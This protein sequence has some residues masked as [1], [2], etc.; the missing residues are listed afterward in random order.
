MM[1][2]TDRHCRV[3][4]RLLSKRARLYSEMVTTEAVLHGRRERLIGFDSRE[5]P[6]ALQLGGSNPAR[7]ARAAMVAEEMGYDEVNLNVGCPSDRVQNGRF[8]ACLMAEPDLVADCV[9]GMMAAVSIPIT[10]KCRIG[11][12][13][14]DSE[15]DFQR[16]VERVGAAGCRVFIVHA[17]KAWLKGLSPKENREVPP[18]DYDR[19]VRMKRSRP[20]LT[21]AING[22]IET[23]DAGLALIDQGL[24]GMMLG[25]A[26]Y[27]NP[28]LLAD[29]D[30]RVFG[31]KSGPV[32]RA[33]V[34]ERFIPYAEGHVAAGGRLSEVTRH[35]LGLY[36]GEPGGRLFRRVLSE[37]A[38]RPG[39]GAEVL[40]KAVAATLNA[41]R[42]KED[43]TIAAE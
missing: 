34:I 29:V 31:A 28:W 1:D 39:A 37:D 10:V 35:I 14:Q 16:F 42:A 26:A 17:R 7:L 43:S 4:H 8:G 9:S 21:I 33:E 32:S 24:D 15:A 11:I 40:R 20:D 27:H 23:L 5:H 12:D 41:R 18:L 19:V 2:W 36:Y 25:R 30:R 22:G 3:F 38:P 13:D 6:V